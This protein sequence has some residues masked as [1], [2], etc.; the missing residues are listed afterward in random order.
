MFKN[1]L[2]IS[3][4]GHCV[5]LRLNIKLDTCITGET[6]RYFG[7]F[8]FYI[9]LPSKKIF[10]RAEINL[11]FVFLILIKYDSINCVA[12]VVLRSVFCAKAVIHVFGADMWLHW[13][14][15]ESVWRQKDLFTFVTFCFSGDEFGLWFVFEFAFYVLMSFDF[16]ILPF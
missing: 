16:K 15:I 2:R 10:S 4:G 5:V 14:E 11:R 1:F 3:K 9:W 13:F 7:F 6:N 12:K 8:F